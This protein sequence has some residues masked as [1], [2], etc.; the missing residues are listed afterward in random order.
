MNSIDFCFWLKG[1]FEISDSCSVTDKQ[2]AVIK[3]HLDLVFLHEI[4]PLRD[5]ESESSPS[6]LNAAHLSIS[7]TSGNDLLVRC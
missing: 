4:D 5:S 1:F 7:N 2:V 6:E 3:G